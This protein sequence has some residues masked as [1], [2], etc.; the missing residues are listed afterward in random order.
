MV[1]HLKGLHLPG[2][3]AEPLRFVGFKE[4]SHLHST[5]LTACCPAKAKIMSPMLDLG[6]KQSKEQ[7]RRE[8]SSSCQAV[9]QGRFRFA[10][11][12]STPTSPSHYPEL[13][14]SVA[15][16]TRSR[17]HM[18]LNA[19]APAQP[20]LVPLLHVV[21]VVILA[22]FVVASH[23]CIPPYRP[24]T[25]PPPPR[26]SSSPHNGHYSQAFSWHKLAL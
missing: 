8:Q 2:M 17:F 1:G 21:V 25:Q 13:H 22:A 20:A 4:Q 3:H 14:L 5:H 7:Q 9:S 16:R 23:N 10:A 11:P 19:D 15:K 24:T 18:P 26:H 12:P 6:V